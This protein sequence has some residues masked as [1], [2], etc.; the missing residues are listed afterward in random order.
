MALFESTG[1]KGDF[2]CYIYLIG[3]NNI[4]VPSRSEFKFCCEHT[5]VKR[6]ILTYSQNRLEE[7]RKKS[8][9]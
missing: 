2:I 7:T 5:L 3:A 8:R 1:R 4:R 9:L 6:V